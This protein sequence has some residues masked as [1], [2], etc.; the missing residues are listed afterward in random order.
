MVKM[1]KS[2]YYLMSS[3]YRNIEI[4]FKKN[5]EFELKLELG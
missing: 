1:T 4:R 5:E 2:Y 3:K